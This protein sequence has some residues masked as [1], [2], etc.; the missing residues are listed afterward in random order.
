MCSACDKNCLNTP[1]AMFEQMLECSFIEYSFIAVL[2][3]VYSI[4]ENHQ[5]EHGNHHR[6]N[7]MF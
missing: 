3:L 4:L 7:K 2:L 1:I 5:I 6:I